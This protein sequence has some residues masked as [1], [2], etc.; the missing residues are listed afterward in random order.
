MISFDTRTS[1]QVGP[2]RI[3]SHGK[4]VIF[5][6]WSLGVMI[7]VVLA[8]AAL[9]S[10]FGGVLPLRWFRFND[11]QIAHQ[12]LQRD[13]PFRPN[14]LIETNYFEGDEA[15]VGNLPKTQPAHAR[16]F[17]T[18]PL[19]FRYTPTA[20]AGQP[21]AV[22]VFRGFSF[23]W[24]AGLSDGETFPAALSRELGVNVYNAARFHEDHEMPSDFD[25]L[26]AK[27]HTN[28][29]I[30]VYVHLEPN[31]HN[32]AWNKPSAF[33]R[34]GERFIGSIF[35]RT[36]KQVS[37]MGNA[38][39]TWMR[40][41]PLKSL[42]VRVNKALR[43]DVILP[44]QYREN[45]CSFTLPNGKPLFVRKGDL[46]RLQT[47]RDETTVRERARYIGWWRDKLAERHIQMIVLL[48]PEKMSVYGPALGLALPRVP[49]LNRLERELTQRGI[50]V[51]NGLPVLRAKATAD[52]ASGHLSYFR[53]DQHW[54]PLGAAHLA[55]ATAQAIKVQGVLRGSSAVQSNCCWRAQ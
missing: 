7:P 16:T 6:G 12:V 48:V 22:V 9:L 40:L 30:A 19:G 50:H 44:N 55:R 20:R 4:T 8:M 15:V 35:V 29:K 45:V 26:L 18:D 39:A 28:P 33:F 36:A 42:A 24:G 46:K 31:E 2:T 14:L 47:E 25:A 52:L 34:L 10:V 37:Y 1:A 17:R 41:A 51:V 5:S 49:Y 3:Q 53:E 23:V 38:A 43:N 21:P 54:T 11:F 13:S 32:L 27:L